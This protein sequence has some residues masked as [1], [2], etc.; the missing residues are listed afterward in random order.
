M[1]LNQNKMKMLVFMMW[2]IKSHKMLLE[3]GED[4]L[5][6][7]DE[8]D[9]NYNALYLCCKKT[10]ESFGGIDVIQN[11]KNYQAVAQKLN[12]QIERM[13]REMVKRIGDNGCTLMMMVV[14]ALRHCNLDN[15]RGVEFDELKTI[16]L[17]SIIARARD[18]E[19]LNPWNVQSLCRGFK[20]GYWEA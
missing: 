16:D 5:P 14:G 4:E 18:E 3:V 6:Q 9:D 11:C 2:V 19:Y 1:R 13:K 7:E 8:Q 12:G 20:F 15:L 17:D 10:L